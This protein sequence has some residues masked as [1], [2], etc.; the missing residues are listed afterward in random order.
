MASWFQYT[1]VSKRAPKKLA[2]ML[3]RSET[4]KT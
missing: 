3:L 4:A 1:P 2:R